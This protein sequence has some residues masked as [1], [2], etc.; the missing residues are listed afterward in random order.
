MVFLLSGQLFVQF[1]DVVVPLGLVAGSRHRSV[2]VVF[3]PEGLDL[4]LSSAVSGAVGEDLL[5]AGQAA[6]LLV[7][8][9]HV[10][11]QT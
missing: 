3:L 8:Q 7:H 2:Q 4:E 10:P 9:P 11:V 6:G 1:G 5:G